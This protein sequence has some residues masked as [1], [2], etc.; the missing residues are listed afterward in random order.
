M[1][2]PCQAGI[3]DPSTLLKL[4]TTRLPQVL[5]A[6]TVPRAEVHTY[7]YI[8]KKVTVLGAPSQ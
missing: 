7:V 1:C 5:Y 6:S 4:S 3:P 2:M 8:Q